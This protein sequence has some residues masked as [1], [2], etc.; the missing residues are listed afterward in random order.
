VIA[1]HAQEWAQRCKRKRECEQRLDERAYV[2]VRTRPPLPVPC[3]NRR[4]V[5]VVVGVGGLGVNLA[6]R[7]LVDNA[8]VLCVL[9]GLARP[10]RSKS[11]PG[12]AFLS[13]LLPSSGLA[14]PAAAAACPS[15]RTKL[16]ALPVP[17]RTLVVL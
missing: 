7:V 11:R 16:G 2:V 12:A 10:L 6:Q 4:L 5:L 13:T 8:Y 9:K 15:G 17:L 1:A 14:R 3:R